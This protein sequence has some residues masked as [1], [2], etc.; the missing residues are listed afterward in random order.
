M[1]KKVIVTG[2]GK[3]GTTFFMKLLTELGY[4]TGYKVG[5][6]PEDTFEWR[7]RGRHAN[8]KNQPYVIKSPNLCRDLL[9]RADQWD[10]EIKHVYVLLRD[11]KDVANNKWQHRHAN[12]GQDWSPE[13]KEEIMQEYVDTAAGHI[14][15]L[16]YQVISSDVPHTYLMFPRIITDPRYLWR[17]CTIL[18]NISYETFKAAFDKVADLGRVHWGLE[19]MKEYDL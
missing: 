11:Y 13:Q 2:S 3:C 17:T 19:R 8:K 7:I 18:N 5:E 14:G 15:H 9:D 4:D 6:D 1:S 12:D 10:W 16:V